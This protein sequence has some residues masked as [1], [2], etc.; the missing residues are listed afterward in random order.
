MDYSEL[1][2][3][4]EGE[5]LYNI[6]AYVPLNNDNL[7]FHNDINTY[8]YHCDFD[9][10]K[11][12]DDELLESSAKDLKS[13][14]S[15][16]NDVSKLT[17]V[18]NN[19]ISCT[20]F[21]DTLF[22]KHNNMSDNLIHKLYNKSNIEY[23]NTHGSNLNIQPLKSLQNAQNTFVLHSAG[24]QLKK[25]TCILYNINLELLES[26]RQHIYTNKVSCKHNELN[27]YKQIADLYSVPHK[28]KICKYKVYKEE[29]CKYHYNVKYNNNCKIEGCR[30]MIKIHGLCY[31]HIKPI[32]ILKNCKNYTYKNYELCNRHLAERIN[33]MDNRKVTNIYPKVAISK[34]K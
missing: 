2:D 9:Y 19:S 24:P 15:T 10:H 34:S 23:Y 8:L 14:D 21:Q 33:A 32:C 4:L 1:Y 27:N 16:S 13:I 5:N 22:N 28:E 12:E 6:D 7:I 17:T 3:M 31:K 30:N 20:P 29:L 25:D 11:L 18:E 26:V